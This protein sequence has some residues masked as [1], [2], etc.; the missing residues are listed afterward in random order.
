VNPPPRDLCERWLDNCPWTRCLEHVRGTDKPLRKRP[1]C[2][3]VL[4]DVAE[5]YGGL[6]FSEIAWYLGVDP[7]S[8][9][10]S[11]SSALVKLRRKAAA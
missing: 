2:G 11:F 5:L 1:V 6:R 3:R 8:V 10:Q 7:S 9:R 4:N